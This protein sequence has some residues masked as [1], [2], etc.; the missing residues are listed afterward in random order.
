MKKYRIL[1]N[2]FA[3]VTVVLLCAMCTVVSF[4]YGSYLC[5][6]AH[7]ATSFPAEV[8]FLYAIPFLI[9][10]AVTGTLYFVFRK[11]AQVAGEQGE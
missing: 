7:H 1:T 4:S 6:V 3:A 9:A 10:I 8:A 2:V 5:A 11:K